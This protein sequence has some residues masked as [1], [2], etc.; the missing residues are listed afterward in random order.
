MF[1]RIMA[2]L[3]VLHLDQLETQRRLTLVEIAMSSSGTNNLP[4]SF[5]E[6][7]KL[8]LPLPSISEFEIFYLLLETRG[9]L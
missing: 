1:S 4:S 3:H 6:K 2:A 9:K 5:A 7:H 8:S